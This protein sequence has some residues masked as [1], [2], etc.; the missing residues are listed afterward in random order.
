AFSLFILMNVARMLWQT[1]IL[2]LQASLDRKLR[3]TIE[4][5]LR[6]LDHVSDLHHL[7]VWSLDGE[8]HV[9]SVHVVVA[10]CLE[11]HSQIAWQG[12][13]A[14]VLSGLGLLHTTVGLEL[15]EELC[16]DPALPP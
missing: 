11:L 6:Q 9:L 14:R 7:H 3:A 15:P 8:H 12:E 5:R 13:I 10:T 4:E 2:F 16:R 1:A